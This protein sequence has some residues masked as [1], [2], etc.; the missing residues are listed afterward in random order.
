MPPI[1]PL[2]QVVKSLLSAAEWPGSNPTTPR[3]VYVGS[4]I[5]F[6]YRGQRGRLIHDTYPFVIVSDIFSDA[7]RGM[8]LNYLDSINVKDVILNYLDNPNFHYR[9]AVAQNPYYVDAYRTYK[10]SGISQQRIYDSRFLRALAYVAPRLD[11]NEINQIEQQIEMMK[12]AAMRQPEA[13]ET[14]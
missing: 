1:I 2:P 12:E 13:D 5:S 4:V 8:N 6:F 10:R 14:V 9:T 7:I 3:N 11:P